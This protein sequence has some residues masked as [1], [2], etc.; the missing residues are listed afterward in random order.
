MIKWSR[1]IGVLV[2]ALTCLNA[3]GTTY[4]GTVRR[5]D[6]VIKFKCT[7]GPHV[8]PAVARDHELEGSVNVRAVINMSG[9]TESAV[10]VK[11][12]GW[13]TLDEVA[14][15]SVRETKC[16]IESTGKPTEDGIGVEFP[17]V[18]SLKE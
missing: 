17:F 16:V 8:Y 6:R 7:L 12:S 14:L 11:S 2:F 9:R 1:G 10:I 3:Y 4:S 13:Q 15:N 18:F 5:A